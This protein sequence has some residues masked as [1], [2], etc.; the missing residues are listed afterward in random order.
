MIKR[1]I[2]I[3]HGGI[4]VLIV[5]STTM[6]RETQQ[7]QMKTHTR[8]KSFSLVLCHGTSSLQKN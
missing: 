2:S 3:K 1:I 6:F 8:I 5:K 7:A 4:P